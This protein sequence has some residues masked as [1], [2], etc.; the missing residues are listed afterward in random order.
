M[1]RISARARRALVE[2]RKRQIL[3]AA[4]KVFATKGYERATIANIAR[5]AGVAEGSIYNY[6]KNKGD[7]LISIPRQAI[8]S[9]VE[10]VTAQM[11][12]A[13]AAPIPPEQMLSIIAK[14]MVSVI[15]QN[16]HIFR[17]L[18]SALP[19]MNQATR[20][21]YLNRVLLYVWD[22][23]EAYF[24]E[25]IEKGVFR[26]DLNP[27][28]LTRTFVGMFLPF[29]L[30]DEILLVHNPVTLDYDQVVAQVITVFLRGALV[31]GA[32]SNQ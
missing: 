4:I 10:S 17:I 2:E 18:I 15:R 6:F 30:L 1:P 32:I 11:R 8:Q 29:V 7:L 21:Q 27:A 16:G 25:L 22:I 26:R 23:L 19:T 28:I 24:T 13:T 12:S 9:P 5:E 14:N 31:E 3:N 20:E